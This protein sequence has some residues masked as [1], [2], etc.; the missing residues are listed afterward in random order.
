MKVYLIQQESTNNYKIGITKHANVSKRI[1]QLQ[2][3]SPEKLILISEFLTKHNYM[4]ETAVQNYFKLN[5][6]NN[7]WFLNIDKDQF[8]NFCKLTESNFDYL[9]EH[10]TYG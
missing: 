2:T 9:K 3:A 6:I 5:K 7:E 1:R 4:L 10:S 8:I